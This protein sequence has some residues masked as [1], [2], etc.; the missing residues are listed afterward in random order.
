MGLLTKCSEN[1]FL[2]LAGFLA[3]GLSEFLELEGGLSYTSLSGLVINLVD[4]SENGFHAGFD[5]L[6]EFFH[7]FESYC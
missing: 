6:Y 5:V 1:Y 4:V 3:I 2:L 7:D